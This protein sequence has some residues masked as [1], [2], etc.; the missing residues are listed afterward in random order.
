M[1]CTGLAVIARDHTGFLIA[2]KVLF[3]QA[4]TSL[5]AEA[6]A[7]RLGILLARTMTASHF[8]FETDCLQLVNMLSHSNPSTDWAVQPLVEHIQALTVDMGSHSW[9]WTSRLANQAAD[10]MASLVRQRSVQLIGFSFHLP[11]LLGSFC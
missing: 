5:V 11:L 2:G 6:L 10:H 9:E 1:E 3:T 8:I 4:P 7:L